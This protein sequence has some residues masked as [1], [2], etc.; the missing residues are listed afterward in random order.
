MELANSKLDLI[1]VR[2]V[3]EVSGAFRALVGR[4]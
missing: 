4:Y 2:L 1:C 3:R